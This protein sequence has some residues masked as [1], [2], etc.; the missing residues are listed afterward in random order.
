M[1]KFNASWK[2]SFPILILVVVLGAFGAFKFLNNSNVSSRTP[3]IP[4]AMALDDGYTY[5]TIVAITSIMENA[6]PETEYDFYIMHPNAFGQENKDKLMSLEKKYNRCHLNLIDMEDKYKN[7]NDKGH[8]TTP[9]Y[10]RLSLSELLPK[11]NK[12]IW[13]DGDTLTLRDL[14]EM[15]EIDMS[16]YYYKGFLDDNVYGVKNFVDNDHCICSGVMLVNLEELRKDNMVEKFERFIEENN[17]KLIQHDQ[18]TINAVAYKKIGKLPLRYGMFAG[19]CDLESITLHR[20]NLIAKDNYTD[21]EIIDGLNN[22]TVV[23]CVSKPWKSKGVGFFK[24][25][26]EYAQKTDFYEEIKTAYPII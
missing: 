24:Q 23:H 16:G 6:N 3:N 20:N 21:E 10:Y 15:Y 13:L 12:I 26:W 8:V 17:D 22:L 9:A 25:W 19:L 18:T 2:K 1:K 4:I 11:L 7:A 5:P 14:K